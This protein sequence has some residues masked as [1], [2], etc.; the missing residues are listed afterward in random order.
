MWVRKSKDVLIAEE[1]AETRRSICAA[2]QRRDLSCDA[3]PNAEGAIEC[4]SHNNY[5][6]V[7]LDL[8]TS[9]EEVFEAL[10][11]ADPRRVSTTRK[12]IVVVLISFDARRGLP[13]MGEGVH[14]LLRK[15]VELRDLVEL[16]AGCIRI[17][18]EHLTR[19]VDGH[20]DD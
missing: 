3:A 4:L 8:S 5:A 17:R 12:P 14:A 7:L 6:V 13:V 10:N 19:S 1:D 11:A 2:L 15:P 16:V 20:P 18:R 9:Y